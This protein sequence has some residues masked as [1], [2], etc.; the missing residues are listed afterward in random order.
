M[1]Q[2]TNTMMVRRTIAV[3]PALMW[4]AWTTPGE[5]AKWWG[6]HGFSSTI[7]EMDV[8]PG[9]LWRLTMHGPDGLNYPNTATYEEVTK[10]E[11]IAF[12]H[13]QSKELDLAEWQS[14]I[15]FYADG[16]RTTV[17][18]ITRYPST[19]EMNKHV[20]KFGAVEGAEQTL[21]RLDRH[22]EKMAQ[23]E[24]TRPQPGQNPLRRQEPAFREQLDE[25]DRRN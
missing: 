11:K 5:I 18:M 8:R 7:E 21:E 20:D 1:A 16:A 15:N 9:G 10:P 22:L 6:P 3:T 17:T 4:E 2:D 14:E 23:K 24:A 12:R 19:V 13:H 25:D